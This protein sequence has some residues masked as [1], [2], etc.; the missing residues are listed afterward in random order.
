MLVAMPEDAVPKAILAT[1]MSGQLVAKFFSHDDLKDQ[2]SEEKGFVQL[3]N[4]FNHDNATTGICSFSAI[5]AF[6][7]TQKL[8]CCIIYSFLSSYSCT[9]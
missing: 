2:F 4:A 6:I 9:C 5:T 3:N 8:I 7:I 1:A